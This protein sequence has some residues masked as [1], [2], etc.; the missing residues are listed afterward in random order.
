[1]RN[2]KWS[3]INR[4][5]LKVPLPQEDIAPFTFLPVS[6]F[7]IEK[8]NKREVLVVAEDRWGDES[9]MCLVIT[10]DGK[11]YKA[12]MPSYEIVQYCANSFAQFI[13]IAERYLF[14]G[15]EGD[16]ENTEQQEALFRADAQQIDPS[17]FVDEHCFWSIYAEEV[18]YGF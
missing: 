2:T 16:R 5:R 1:M 12:E 9:G 8:G 17:A 13:A 10:L 3:E 14:I 11:V 7:R 15:E 6:A 4:E 18:G